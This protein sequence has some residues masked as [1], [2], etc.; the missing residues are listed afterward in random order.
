M[1]T[2]K[3][4]SGIVPDTRSTGC[5]WFKEMHSSCIYPEGQ[6]YT[7]DVTFDKDFWDE[8]ERRIQFL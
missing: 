8:A 4:I 5:F 2:F 3:I 1:K 6:I 7:V